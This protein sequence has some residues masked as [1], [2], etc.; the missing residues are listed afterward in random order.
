MFVAVL[1][2]PAN[3][4]FADHAEVTIVT[5]DESGFSQACAASQGGSGCYTPVTATVDVGGVVT[6]I[7]TD[8]TGVHTFTSGTVD[9]FAP[10]PDLVFDTSVLM[11]GDSFEWIPTQAGEQPYYCM[12]HTWMIGTIIVQE[13]VVESDVTQ[14][15]I[16]YFTIFS[17]DD[18]TK[19]NVQGDVI[20]SSTTHNLTYLITDSNGQVVYDYPS[21]TM[22]TGDQYGLNGP[23]FWTVTSYN[24]GIPTAGEYTSE[25]NGNFTLK[26]CAS[27]HGIC[28]EESF[29]IN[30]IVEDTTPPTITFHSAI[31]N[32]VVLPYPAPNFVD[33]EIFTWLEASTTASDDV[34]IDTSLGLPIFN[35]AWSTPGL[36]CDKEYLWNIN[37][38][39]WQEFPNGDTTIT[40]KAWDTSGNEATASFT[41]TLNY[42]ATADT[43]P[44]VISFVEI[45]RQEPDSNYSDV[46]MD[47][48]LKNYSLPASGLPIIFPVGITDNSTV[49]DTGSSE[50][51]PVCTVTKSNNSDPLEYASYTGYGSVSGYYEMRFY[52]NSP[53][54]FLIEC[55]ASDA[56]GNTDTASF[57]VNTTVP[58][59]VDTTPPVFAVPDDI[60]FNG[61]AIQNNRQLLDSTTN[62]PPSATDNVDGTM[63]APTCTSQPT[64]VGIEVN[65]PSSWWALVW[66]YGTYTITCSAT[67]TSGNTGTASFTITVNAFVDTTPPVI[68]VPTGMTVMSQSSYENSGNPLSY[69]DYKLDVANSS[70][71]WPPTAV[72]DW[73]GAIT[74][75]SD[76]FFLYSQSNNGEPSFGC[77]GL[78]ANSISPDTFFALLGAPNSSTYYSPPTFGVGPGVYPV[79]CYAMDSA[80]NRSEST[81]YITVIEDTGNVQA[82]ADTTPSGPTTASGTFT[83]TDGANGGHCTNIGI[84]DS[85]SK[86]CDVT[87]DIDGSII[88]GS[89]GITI[90]GNGNTLF[91]DP[92]SDGGFIS[93][94]GVS[95]VVIQNFNL[96]G[97]PVP[98]YENGML[99]A[100]FTNSDNI[101][102]QQNTFTDFNRGLYFIDVSNL[103]IQNNSLL[104][105]QAS[106][107]VSGS[108]GVSITNNIFENC[109]AHCILLQAGHTT[110][111]ISDNAF[112]TSSSDYIDD[113]GVPKPFFAIDIGYA[114]VN[115]ASFGTYTISDNTFTGDDTGGLIIKST[116]A[117]VIVTDNAFSNLNAAISMCGNVRPVPGMLPDCEVDYQIPTQF[118]GN[119]FTNNIRHDI[120]T[121]S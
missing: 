79:F 27:D 110:S 44:P 57:T 78:N 45:I 54:T 3:D 21:T 96:I 62:F 1:L 93:G 46:L 73:D 48:Q 115:G 56:A 109:N 51:A 66:E 89:D 32:G 83:V 86:T 15:T 108:D 65:E 64:V 112:T 88:I 47:G 42:V 12:L 43:T 87:A 26:I 99:G 119:T 8:P 20:G 33:N 41:V 114:D 30:S 98:Q 31:A 50:F 77:E 13:A 60:T 49:Y 84:W 37:H 38:S 35:H 69:S 9:G 80:G 71:N 121:C 53:H 6:M 105:S 92:L 18:H 63:G 2:I 102:I 120:V 113:F 103:Q 19:F 95:D 74:T 28:V 16:D 111:L 22:S 17:E 4:A 117:T 7:N 25:Y 70:A 10:S 61:L 34:A 23:V 106:I 40:C 55:T 82:P 14:L 72:D 118:S 91:L 52:F 81:F 100:Y 59:P 11:S 104:N 76:G 68:A 85:D 5:V 90:N 29:T 101:I 75:R 107:E 39:S 58:A 94:N 24:Q 36:N 97:G 116:G 67:D